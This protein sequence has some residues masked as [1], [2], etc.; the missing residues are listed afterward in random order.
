MMAYQCCRCYNS[1]SGTSELLRGKTQTPSLS[2]QPNCR[3][4]IRW[5]AFVASMV[6]MYPT[7]ERIKSHPVGFRQ[8]MPLAYSD[9]FASGASGH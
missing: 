4:S 8:G 1:M 3:F 7:L 5:A 6:G 9:S 2:H